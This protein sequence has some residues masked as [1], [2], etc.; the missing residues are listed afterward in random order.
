MRLALTFLFLAVTTSLV[1]NDGESF[2]FRTG[3]KLTYD[4]L[5]GPIVAGHATLHVT[6]IETIDGKDCYHLV[7]RAQTS[8]VVDLIF[9]V[10][11]KIESWLDTKDLFTRRFRQVRLERKHRTADESHYDYTTGQIVTTN[12]LNG[13][14]KSSPL[15]NAG[16]DLLS[17]FYF[18]RTLPLHLNYEVN[19]PITLT[20]VRYDM[21]A[22][23][24][25]RKHFF[26]RPTGDVPAL[27]IEPNPTLNVVASCGGRMWFWV[28]DD[29]RR[30]PVLLVSDIKFGSIKMVLTGIQS[31][32]TTQTRM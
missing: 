17:A 26:S 10:E 5:W 2:P 30:L 6:G 14:L 23:L 20:G 4:I 24:D 1:A 28:S 12:L 22:R 19:F 29:D 21:H 3:E 8:G 18:V 13:K 25:E 32:Q 9:H 31:N 7:G 15:P 11:N 27:R 16:Q